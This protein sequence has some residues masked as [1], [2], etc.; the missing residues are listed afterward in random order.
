MSIAVVLLIAYR[1]LSSSLAAD[2]PKGPP[3]VPVS[4]IT[5]E[6]KDVPQLAAG[7]GTVQ[8]LHN[9][10]LRPQVSGIVT[11]VLFE[12]GQ[13][14]KRGQLLAAFGPWIVVKPARAA[15]AMCKAVMSLNPISSFGLARMVVKSR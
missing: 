4:V 10:I 9:V 2:P 15:K 1:L 14:V 5:V 3:P 7:I 13:H 12:E 6:Q 11:E 8:S